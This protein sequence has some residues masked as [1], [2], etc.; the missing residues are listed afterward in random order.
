MLENLGRC[1]WFWAV[2][3]PRHSC[4]KG[5]ALV[6]S[7]SYSAICLGLGPSA[8]CEWPEQGK[9]CLNQCGWAA[10]Y[11]FRD[12]CMDGSRAPSPTLTSI[13]MHV[14]PHFIQVLV[15]FQMLSTN[16]SAS[17]PLLSFCLLCECF[18]LC[19]GPW[20]SS[21]NINSTAERKIREIKTSGN[22]GFLSDVNDEPLSPLCLE[23]H[24]PVFHFSSWDIFK[25]YVWAELLTRK[26]VSQACLSSALYREEKRQEQSN[27]PSSLLVILEFG[28]S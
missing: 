15:V 12:N 18:V 13:V 19:P 26:V 21:C 8:A 27:V 9:Q 10:T 7:C 23:G 1:C 6:L 25:Q 3:T 11:F 16:H 24:H 2:P 28:G 14:M 20:E 17:E 5:W 22:F 4:N